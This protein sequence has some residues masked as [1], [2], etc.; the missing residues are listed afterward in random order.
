MVMIFAP[1][2]S[3]RGCAWLGAMAAWAFCI[4]CLLSG[5]ADGQKAAGR[6]ACGGGRGGLV[7]WLNVFFVFGVCFQD[8]PM[9]KKLLEG[10]PVGWIGWIGRGDEGGGWASTPGARAG[11]RD[12][13]NDD[14]AGQQH[15][16][17]RPGADG[18]EQR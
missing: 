14:A 7:K 16:Q 10:L 12:D 3:A 13:G 6:T 15:A 1:V 17:A 11:Q 8:L 18:V 9:G 4:P 2:S 5:F